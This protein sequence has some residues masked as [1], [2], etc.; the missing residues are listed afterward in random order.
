MSSMW[1]EGGERAHLESLLEGENLMFAEEADQR[2]DQ[3]H[4]THVKSGPI[5][6]QERRKY[7]NAQPDRA[8]RCFTKKRIWSYWCVDVCV[9]VFVRTLMSADTGTPIEIDR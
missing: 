8:A 7:M 1:E 4:W 3:L 2:G 9:R 6:R 5:G